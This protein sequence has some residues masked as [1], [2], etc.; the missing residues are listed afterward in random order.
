MNC[1]LK[2]FENRLDSLRGASAGGRCGFLNHPFVGQTSSALAEIAAAPKAPRDPEEDRRIVEEINRQTD[3]PELQPH[4]EEDI[5]KMDYAT[6]R[7]MVHPKKGRWL[8][9][10]EDQIKRML[11]HE[12]EKAA[13]GNHQSEAH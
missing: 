5:D 6:V 2:R 8:R 4:D 11:E 10:S 7:R 12:Q 1:S 9:F 13:D 3:S